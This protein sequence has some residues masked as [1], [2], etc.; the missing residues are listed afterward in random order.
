MS[1]LDLTWRPRP[2]QVIPD[3]PD[4]V[5]IV[6]YGGR[7]IGKTWNGCR[8][9][10]T[11][12]LTHP[13][14]TWAAVAQTWG[15]AERILALGEGG[16]RWHIEGDPDNPD[17]V[18]RRPDLSV[19]LLGGK[20]ETA[21]RSAPGRMVL[22]FA[23]GSEIRFAS[24]DK[25]KSLRGGNYHGALADEVAFWDHEAWH[26]LRLAVRLKLPDGSPSRILA[27]TTPN[28][29][30]W[31]YEQ[32]LDVAKLPRPEV[33]FVGGANGGRLLPDPPPSTFDNP[34][35]DP[36]WRRQLL[37][38]YDGT[39]LGRQELYGEVLSLTGAVF[40]GLSLVK[41]TRAGF[42]DRGGVWLTPDSAD[43]I[44]AGLDLGAE[45][46]SALVVCAR[47]D[48]RWY[49]V[50]EAAAPCP[51]PQA[52]ADLIDRHV[53]V[54]KPHTIW[55][56]RNFPQTSNFLRK[57]G[58]AVKDVSKDPG[59]VLDGIRELQRQQSQE[60]IVIDREACPVLWK[61]LTGYRWA[62]APDG[63]PL[64]PERPV[65]RDDHTVDALRYAMYM[66]A[67]KKKRKLLTL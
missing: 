14:S 13:G 62:T 60:T 54:W 55:T 21:F 16:L 34:H 19:T 33:A 57:A 24:A 8:W 32:F 20:W 39:D 51:D 40:K 28:G 25:P 10:L 37:D 11:M 65:K 38:M 43:D 6:L 35:T 45:N 48:D 15:D 12:A 49:V 7:G 50:A 5:N 17:E 56:D 64:T 52:V 4:A 9:L 42:E 22:R 2:H 44:I 30:N 59:S 26:M 18:L 3:L 47:K 23:N 66:A 46:P 29:M 36:T 31:F 58:Y 1:E 63:T 61:E 27:A 67:T 53:K 41:H